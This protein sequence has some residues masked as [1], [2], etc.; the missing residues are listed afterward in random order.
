LTDSEIRRA[1]DREHTR[2]AERCRALVTMV[3]VTRSERDAFA[4]ELRGLRDE[5]AAER[6]RR[7]ACECRVDDLEAEL[8]RHKVELWRKVDSPP[9]GR[10][11]PDGRRDGQARV[12]VQ[13]QARRSACD[14]CGCDLCEGRP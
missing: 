12:P 3:A 10:F 1:L 4:A 14:D 5:L 8:A 9:G 6:R 11:V 7:S 2:L 13:E